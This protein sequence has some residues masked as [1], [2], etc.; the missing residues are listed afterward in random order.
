MSM[1]HCVDVLW[2][3]SVQIK[4]VTVVKKIS[5]KNKQID[6]ILAIEKCGTDKS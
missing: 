5:R 4:Y 1:V 6:Y 3:K 2:K